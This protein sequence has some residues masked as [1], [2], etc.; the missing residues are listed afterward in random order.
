MSNEH[1]NYWLSGIHGVTDMDME[2]SV[3]QGGALSSLFDD[4]K[5]C[6]QAKESESTKQDDSSFTEPQ[7]LDKSVTEGDAG[8][9]RK[10]DVEGNGKTWEDMDEDDPD[11]S[12]KTAE[13]HDESEDVKDADAPTMD[14]ADRIDLFTRKV[15]EMP[16]RL[17]V[18]TP[19]VDQ[20]VKIYLFM[21]MV[22]GVM[23][24]RDHFVMRVC[25]HLPSLRFVLVQ[26]KKWMLPGW[27][28]PNYAKIDAYFRGDW[29]A[30][31]RNDQFFK[32]AWSN[33]K[34]LMKKDNRL[35]TRTKAR[36]VI[37]AI[38][39]KYVPDKNVDH[40]NLTKKFLRYANKPGQDNDSELKQT[41]RVPWTMRDAL[42]SS[43]M[44][45]CS[46]S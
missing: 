15:R 3:A 37:D 39:D 11:R 45:V 42:L 27:N 21:C 36:K 30:Y 16:C 35:N 13:S 20:S 32:K 23:L 46:A 18:D 25:Q 7:L 6:N 19:T 5:S 1:A 2:K 29:F 38:L 28:E 26:S 10:S 4:S 8:Q 33:L 41:N 17:D 40:I 9:I 24:Y 22:Y 14:R 12:S 34:S 44:T 31:R 43:W